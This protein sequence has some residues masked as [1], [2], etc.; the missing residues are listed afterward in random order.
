M[1]IDKIKDIHKLVLELEELK[2]QKK[3]IE[4][5]CDEDNDYVLMIVSGENQASYN[6][7]MH[8][9]SMLESY[10]AKSFKLKQKKIEYLFEKEL[11]KLSD[12]IE[13]LEEEIEQF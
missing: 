1:K 6:I 11:E 12:Q 13:K 8:I 3:M 7:D 4:N 9:N 5:N 2:K 10:G